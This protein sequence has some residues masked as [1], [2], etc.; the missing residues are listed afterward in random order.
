MAD[1]T[2]SQLPAAVS[3]SA[4]DYIPVDQGGVTKRA[5]LGMLGN[6]TVIVAPGKT[7]YVN[8]TIT[9]TGTDGTTITLPA[10]SATMARTDAA[11]TFTGVQT[12]S[13][14]IV[15]N[16][17]TAS[18]LFT[19]RT[20]DGVSF[21]GTTNIVVVAPATHAAP[22][23]PTPVDADEIPLTYSALGYTLN[24]VT[25]AN[26][27]A[28]LKTYFDAVY[29]ALA[30]SSSQ[31][32]SVAAATSPAHAVRLDQMPQHPFRNRV[33][34]GDLAVWQIGTTQ[35]LTTSFAYGSADMFAAACGTASQATL[36][37]TTSTVSGLPYAMKLQRTNGVSTT[38]VQYV[39]QVM[40]TATITPLQGQTIA[41]SYWAK[42][43]ANF[44]EAS[45]ALTVL[46]ESGTGV[47]ATTLTATFGGWT[48]AATLFSGTDTLTTSWQR[49]THIVTLGATVT[50]VGFMFSYTPVG[51]AGADDS[52]SITGI[53]F[54]PI[55]TGSTVATS[56][57]LLPYETQLR[58]CQ[59]YLYAID[60]SDYIA[61]QAA[62]ATAAYFP[63]SFKTTMRTVPTGIGYTGT[64]SNY[65]VTD[66]A[67]ATLAC[68]AITFNAAGLNSG[69]I[70]T[71]HATGTVSGNASLFLPNGGI[72]YFTGCTL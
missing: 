35:N 23:N 33:I 43:G 62:T 66:A 18:A 53:Q 22:S 48:G 4:T 72:V 60:G 63:I 71:T 55:V 30:G 47:D 12:F 69:T 52:V 56:Y 1:S 10:T 64:I 45:S 16:I 24:R 49:F 11:Q 6:G 40:E 61:G 65:L 28:T 9:F 37:Q 57:E 25:W 2:I 67:V 46:L 36:S 29:A 8:N 59:R 3:L 27:K 70:V 39:N 50:Q 58:R 5:T 51:T 26:V 44:S 68:S 14:T 41:F 42:A 20:I 13:S 7:L 17:N 15:G 34:N 19:A 31:V 32:F 38:G 21:D 54:E